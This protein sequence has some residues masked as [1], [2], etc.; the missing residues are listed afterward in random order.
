MINHR[1]YSLFQASV[2]FKFIFFALNSKETQFSLFSYFSVNAMSSRSR[3][4]LFSEEERFLPLDFELSSDDDDDHIEHKAPISS[5]NEIEVTPEC[6]Q[7]STNT[8]IDQYNLVLNEK[9][10]IP[11]SAT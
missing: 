6:I 2:R 7:T 8:K 1:I 3:V 11:R 10:F 5:A 4:G 9:R